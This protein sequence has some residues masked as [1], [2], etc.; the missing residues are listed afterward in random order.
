MRL[1][2]ICSI[3]LLVLGHLFKLNNKWVNTMV[4]LTNFHTCKYE[5]MGCTWHNF[6]CEEV[7]TEA[8]PESILFLIVDR[9]GLNLICPGEIVITLC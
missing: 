1:L 3:L 7:V 2:L 8:K 5:K 6:L 9:F 4:F